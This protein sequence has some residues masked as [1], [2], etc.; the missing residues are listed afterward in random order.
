MLGAGIAGLFVV[1][2]SI[3]AAPVVML[4]YAGGALAGGFI[5]SGAGKELVEEKYDLLGLDSYL[6]SVEKELEEGIPVEVEAYIN[7]NRYSNFNIS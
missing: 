7:S 5:G 4:L 1:G 3:S 2:L 6:D